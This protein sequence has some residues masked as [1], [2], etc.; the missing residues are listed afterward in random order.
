M[1]DFLN[2]RITI[3]NDVSAQSLIVEC[4]QVKGIILDNGETIKAEYTIVAP[5]REGADWLTQ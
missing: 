2:D 5:G 4:E 1:Q 3:L